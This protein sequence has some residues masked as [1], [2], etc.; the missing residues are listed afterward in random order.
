MSP[1]P[2]RPEP[3]RRQRWILPVLALLFMGPLAAAWFFYY[4]GDGWRP[5]T[6]VNH[7]TLI[8][9]VVALQLPDQATSGRLPTLRDRWSLVIVGNRTCDNACIAVL[10]KVRRVRLALRD[11]APRVGRV[12]LHTGALPQAPVLREQWLGLET[13]RVDTAPGA[14]WYQQFAAIAP[15]KQPDWLVYIVDPLGN[16]VLV[17]TPDFAMRG[18]LADLKRLLKLSRIG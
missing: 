12:L 11:K 17:F 1:E 10:D 3:I 18:M 2:L 15:G 6:S 14:A 4:A 9:P 13:L 7:G 5:G 8:T 16:A